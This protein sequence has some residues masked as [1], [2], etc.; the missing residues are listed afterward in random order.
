MLH[1]FVIVIK[2]KEYIL[3]KYKFILIH[4]FYTTEYKNYKVSAC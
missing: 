4:I 3:Y 1:L 2:F